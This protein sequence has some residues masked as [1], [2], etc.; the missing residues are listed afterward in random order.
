VKYIGYLWLFLWISPLYCYKDQADYAIEA[1]DILLTYITTDTSCNTPAYVKKLLYSGPLDDT[2][3]AAYLDGYTKIAVIR[4]MK[5]VALWDEPSRTA[6]VDGIREYLVSV[7]RMQRAL[8]CSICALLVLELG[9]SMYTI[10][11]FINY[12]TYNNDFYL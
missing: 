7:S 5:R 9:V 11:F 8:F 2:F 6:I 3:N 1:Y 10:R 12:Y 4:H